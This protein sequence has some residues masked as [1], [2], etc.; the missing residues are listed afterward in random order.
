MIEGVDYSVDRPS[1]IGLVTVGKRFAGRYVGPGFG[2][3]ML[4]RAEA[5][6]LSRAGLFIVSLVEGAADDALQGYAKGVEHA[7]LAAAWHKDQG[8]P[9]PVVCYAA[10]DFDVQME[11]WPAVRDYFQGFA[12][13]VGLGY[14][15]IY[16]GLNAVQ[17]AQADDVARWF[18]QTYAWSSGVWANG[19]HLQQYRNDVSLVGGTVDLDRATVNS[20]GQWNLSTPIGGEQQDMGA[21]ILSGFTNQPDWTEG[22]YHVADAS[23]QGYHVA[24]LEGYNTVAW[25]GAVALSPGAVPAKYDYAAIT[26]QLFGA[27]QPA[28]VEDQAAPAQPIDAVAVANALAAN[29]DLVA[30]LGQAVAA[31]L[32]DIQASISLSGTLAGGM[33][34]KAA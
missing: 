8:F 17:W 28:E 22:R 31:Q 9:W 18:F 32:S 33:K 24:P 34:P 5:E 23:P 27:P 7:E 2:A 10:V 20:Y 12:Q 30:Q 15:G 16:G 19:V 13:V 26:A 1:P 4:L 25:P 29:A 3:K 14:T 11:Q 6:L 21:Y